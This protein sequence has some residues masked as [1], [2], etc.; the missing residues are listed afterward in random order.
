[1]NRSQMMPHGARLFRLWAAMRELMD[2]AEETLNDPSIAPL[3]DRA[4]GLWASN[5]SWFGLHGHLWMSPLAAVQSQITLRRRFATEPAFHNATQVR[6]PLGARASALYSIAQRVHSR[7][8]KLRHYQQ[9]AS[10]ATQAI[11]L[12][13]NARQGSLSIRGHASMQMAGL[14]F[15]WKLWD[16]ADDFKQSL[17]LRES[18]G[19]SAASVGEAK[20][21]LGLCS[22]LLGRWRTGIA[23]Q[24]EGVTLMRNN[25]SPNGKAFLARGLRSLELGARIIRRK[26]IVAAAWEERLRLAAE[27]EA[28]DQIRA[29]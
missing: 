16:A 6:E 3:W 15:L 7:P 27:I 9:V 5:A 21:D 23:L 13:A 25:D 4:F 8:R 18:S 11:E 2:D 1:M 28:I 26:D 20:V 12:D 29:A 14:G 22:I 10:L 24:Q 19:E 17:K